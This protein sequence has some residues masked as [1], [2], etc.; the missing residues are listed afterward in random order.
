[1][2]LLCFSLTIQAGTGKNVKESDSTVYYLYIDESD[3]NPMN[4]NI[5]ELKYKG[6]TIE[7]YFWG[8]SDEFSEAREGYLPGF[9]VLKM[10]NVKVKNDSIFFV[11]NSK[12]ESYFS[13]SIDI[14]IHTS[15]AAIK[16]GYHLWRQNFSFFYDSIGYKGTISHDGMMLNKTKYPYLDTHK[17]IR[18][19]VDKIKMRNRRLSINDE[20]NNTSFQSFLSRYF[21]PWKQTKVSM[22]IF[23]DATIKDLKDEDL[24]T[25]YLPSSDLSTCKGEMGWKGGCYV[26]H[27]DI[28]LAFFHHFWND[29]LFYS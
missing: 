1:L 26:Q 10:K 8:N 7:G 18:T 9:F 27:K 23:G 2:I 25:A 24:Y 14:S 20:K 6:N 13:N 19:S 22:Q 12:N 16:R 11:L 29:Y 28:I 15:K 4:D 21:R 3:P 17:F 5:I